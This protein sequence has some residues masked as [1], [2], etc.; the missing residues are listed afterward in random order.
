MSRKMQM[1]IHLPF[2]NGGNSMSEL[3]TIDET[4]S[5]AANDE[6]V[7]DDE[8]LLLDLWEIIGRKD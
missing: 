6:F 2:L 1:R 5:A 3:R 8:S 4:I 7:S